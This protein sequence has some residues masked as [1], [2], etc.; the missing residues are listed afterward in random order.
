[1][2]KFFYLYKIRYL[3]NGNKMFWAY[4][5]GQLSKRQLEMLDKLM[6]K[7]PK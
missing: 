6:E 4:I 1:M 7:Y 5:N 3:I 2:R